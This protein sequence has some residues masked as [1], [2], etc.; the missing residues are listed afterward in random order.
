VSA[1][2]D[3]SH[4]FVRRGSDRNANANFTHA[5]G[6]GVREECINTTDSVAL[7]ACTALLIATGVIA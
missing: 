6:H 5:S 3:E 1:Y 4:D 7:A 2:D